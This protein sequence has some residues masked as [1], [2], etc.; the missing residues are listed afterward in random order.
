[1]SND[2]K[3]DTDKKLDDII[4][5]LNSIKDKGLKSYEN[6]TTKTE[7]ISGVVVASKLY[8]IL[9][10]D[11]KGSIDQ[12]LIVSPSTSFSL[13]VNADKKK[14]IDHTYTWLAT[15]SDYINDMSAFV[16]GGVYYASLRDIIFK[17][18]FSIY[19]NT[20]AS[21]TFPLIYIKYNIIDEMRHE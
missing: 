10:G 9:E 16:V 4:T 17:E 21:I 2:F 6:Y 3:N 1:M 8:R 15:Y 11:G 19:V 20:T 5:I 14:Y 12:I 18:H 13:R 7:I